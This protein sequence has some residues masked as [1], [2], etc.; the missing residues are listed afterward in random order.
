VSGPE[1]TA[2]MVGLRR[3][4]YGETREGG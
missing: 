1:Q 2:V 4:A 3:R